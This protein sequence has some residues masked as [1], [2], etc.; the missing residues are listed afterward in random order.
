MKTKINPI[1]F[2]T[3]F[4]CFERNDC[5]SQIYSRQFFTQIT[6]L[7][8]RSLIKPSIFLLQKTSLNNSAHLSGALLFHP[9]TF[10]TLNK[11]RYSFWCQLFPIPKWKSDSINFYD[12]SPSERAWFEIFLPKLG[13]R[14]VVLVWSFVRLLFDRWNLRKCEI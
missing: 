5:R 1:W 2:A 7:L 10:S 12:F 8:V 3:H 4:D 11:W 13:G 6:G 9:S 14:R